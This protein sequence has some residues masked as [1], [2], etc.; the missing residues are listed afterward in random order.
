MIPT[1]YKPTLVL[2][3]NVVVSRGSTDW[4]WPFSLH[5]VRTHVRY[6]LTLPLIIFSLK[7]F[8]VEVKKT[9][10][11]AATLYNRN[12]PLELMKRNQNHCY[13]YELMLISKHY[14]KVLCTIRL[15]QQ[16]INSFLA[17]IR[18]EWTFSVITACKRPR[19]FFGI[20]NKKS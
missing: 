17:V 3:Q 6:T 14:S 2:F 9:L 13:I 5:Y 7:M 20:E 15:I 1:R 18:T 8:L 10:R 4:P 12:N 11:T 19:R 16:L